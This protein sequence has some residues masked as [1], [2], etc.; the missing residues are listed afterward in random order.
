MAPLAVPPWEG[1]ILTLR[2]GDK[3]F[4]LTLL[5]LTPYSIGPFTILGPLMDI[6]GR[7]AKG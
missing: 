4:K 1:T 7:Y 6:R 3:K 5:T 2:E